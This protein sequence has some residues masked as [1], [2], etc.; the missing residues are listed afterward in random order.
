MFYDTFEALCHEKG[1]APSAL[2]RKLGMSS[3]APGRWKTGSSPDLD[4]ARKLANYFGVTI[5]YLVYGEERAMANTMGDV[6]SSAVI[7]GNNSSRVSVSN[8][9]GGGTTGDQL[10]GFEAELLRI[11]RSL[12]MKGKANLIQAAYSLEESQGDR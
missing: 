10:Q 6:T 8:A 1:I 4:T 2:T 5:D 12:D 9:S 7:Q 3:S 11:F